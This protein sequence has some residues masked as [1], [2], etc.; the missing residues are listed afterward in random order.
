M[1]I[2]LE[3]QRLGGLLPQFGDT[4]LPPSASDLAIASDAYLRKLPD[5]YLYFIEKYG[6]SYFSRDVWLKLQ[7]NT[8]LYV[9]DEALGFPRVL[10]PDH[11]ALDGFHGGRRPDHANSSFSARIDRLADRLPNGFVPIA[12]DGSGNQFCLGHSM[13]GVPGIY[14]WDHEY[15][16][17]KEDYI[18]ETGAKMPESAKYQNIYFV[19]NSFSDL[20]KI[21][22]VFT[23]Q[24]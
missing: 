15:E 16:W 17:D 8:P 13:D 21:L 7:S 12:D 4:F 14:F 2:E 3:I 20:F 5:D 19:S 23:P 18:N 1:S 10:G 11:V 6:N 9:H 24:N 22:R